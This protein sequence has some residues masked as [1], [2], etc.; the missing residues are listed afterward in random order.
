MFDHSPPYYAVL[1]CFMGEGY[2]DN[3][4]IA[5]LNHVFQLPTRKTYI[6]ISLLNASLARICYKHSYI[7]D[8]CPFS[9]TVFYY[10]YILEPILISYIPYCSLIN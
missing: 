1:L 2:S 9:G 5:D 6:I 7:V 4:S 3:L 10:K 8:F